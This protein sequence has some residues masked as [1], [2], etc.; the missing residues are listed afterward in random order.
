[1][2]TFNT[3]DF[4][5]DNST[6]LERLCVYNVL[7]V[8]LTHEIDTIL[9]GQQ[10][11]Y[12]KHLYKFQMAV[13]NPLLDIM[14]KGIKVNLNE[15]SKMIRRLEKEKEKILNILTKLAVEVTGMPLNPGSPKQCQNLF[16]TVLNLPP[17]YPRG[18]KKS[19]NPTTD[20]EAL[21]SLKKY[22]YARPFCN[23]IIQYRDV[24]KM[25]G[26][27]KLKLGQDN[28]FYC[29]YGVAGT[30]T[31]RLC[32]HPSTEVLTPKGWISIEDWQDTQPIMVWDQEKNELNFEEVNKKEYPYSGNLIWLNSKR[33]TAGC[34]PEHRIPYLD[35]RGNFKVAFAQE[36]RYLRGVPLGALF[37]GSQWD[38]DVTRICMM[39]QADGSLQG[40]QIKLGF[41]KPRKIDRCEALLD[42]CGLAY[43]RV[44]Y[45]NGLTLFTLLSPPT[46]A[47]DAKF[48]GS[49]LL[50]HD[51]IVALQEGLFWDG[52]G[53]EYCTT[54]KENAL[55]YQT[56]CHLADSSATIRERSHTNGWKTLYRV[57]PQSNTLAR[58]YKN[59]YVEKPHNG[60]VYCAETSTGYF[61]IRNGS[62]I[63]VTGN[64]S[65]KSN[66]GEGANGQNQTERVKKMYVADPGMKMAYIDLEQAESRIVGAL[67]Y[68]LF[69]ESNYL[70]ACESEDLHT[71]VCRMVWDELAWTGEISHDRKVVADQI[72]YRHFSYRDM[73]KRGGHGTNYYGQPFS[74]AKNLNVDKVVMEAFQ[75]RYFNAFPEIRKWHEWTR[76]TLQKQGQL[77]TPFGMKRIFFGRTDQDSTL[78]EGIAFVPQSTIGHLMNLGMYKV[79][80]K[81]PRE[82][83][84]LLNQVHDAILI[85]Y[86]EKDENWLIP[87]LL[88]LIPHPLYARDREVIIPCDAETGWNWAKQDHKG[89]FYPCGNVDGLRGFDGNDTRKRQ[90]VLPHTQSLLSGLPT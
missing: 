29:K 71:T 37:E 62:N 7:D 19:K 5:P 64:S 11:K 8:C 89:K 77:I 69:G 28:R 42:S 75:L 36:K 72:F 30:E 50:E 59:D 78:R 65:S 10:D 1:M 14:F 54:N 17:I 25:L 27:V 86:P 4:D 84:Q 79:W 52:D 58:V 67:C 66:F 51:P 63:S 45:A 76:Q 68:A 40:N 48:L 22:F 90:E 38:N 70:D 83:V 85:Q 15:R 53:E 60:K 74:M 34:T 41:K 57:R 9:S 73:A 80:K 82:K 56:I 23:L 46:W 44:V 47:T 3:R 39:I 24:D 43:N 87:E 6:E 81:Y 35:S 13:Q 18:K 16:Y 21:E 20:N 61:L 49:W 2:K 33:V 32:L 55:W 88:E 12:S 31:G 26:A